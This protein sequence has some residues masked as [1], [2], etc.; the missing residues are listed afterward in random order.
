MLQLAYHMLAYLFMSA[1]IAGAQYDPESAM[2]VRRP[3]VTNVVAAMGILAV[4]T[5]AAALQSKSNKKTMLLLRAYQVNCVFLT[6][7]TVYTL[8]LYRNTIKM[9]HMPG[10]LAGRLLAAKTGWHA[11]ASTHVAQGIE[12]TL[13][14]LGILVQ[15]AGAVIANNLRVALEP[16]TAKEK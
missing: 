4:L 9:K 3:P 7:A 11:G 16:K 5:A 14:M 6:G 8:V 2:H 12:V 1:A 15:L 13:D 10:A